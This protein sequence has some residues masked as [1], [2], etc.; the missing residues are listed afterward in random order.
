[1]WNSLWYIWD[2]KATANLQRVRDADECQ[3]HMV[4]LV[5]SKGALVQL[6]AMTALSVAYT[7]QLVSVKVD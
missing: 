4:Y 3:K 6:Q 5:P 7:P 2:V 1:M